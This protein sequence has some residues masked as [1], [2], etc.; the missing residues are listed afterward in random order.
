MLEIPLRVRYQECDPMGVAHHSVY[1]VWFE[2]GRTELYRVCDL[3]YRDL[4]ATG[5]KLAVIDVSV[6]YR[7]P[8][9]YDDELRLAVAQTGCTRVRLSHAY[10]LRHATSGVILAT[11]TSTLACVDDAGRPQAIPE[12]VANAVPVNGDRPR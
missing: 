6:R 3:S 9:R 10:E 11:A 8:A 4:E 5:A 12:A 1:L 7:R 2:I